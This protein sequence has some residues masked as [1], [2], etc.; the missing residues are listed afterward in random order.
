MQSNEER[1]ALITGRPV[2]SSEAGEGPGE[3][4]RPVRPALPCARAPQ[5]GPQADSRVG[6]VGDAGDPPLELLTRDVGAGGSDPA[7]LLSSLV[8]GGGGGQEQ[9]SP[10]V[11]FSLLLWPLLALVVRLTLDTEYSS[12][13]SHS[14]LLPFP[15]A[16]T[17]LLLTGHLSL[18]NLN[19]TSLLS[20][21]LMLCGLSQTKVTALTRALHLS[22]ILAN[23][24]ALY[25]FSFVLAHVFVELVIDSQLLQ[26]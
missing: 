4:E 23:S 3:T 1:L 22:S 7:A 14:A 10:P 2:E 11:Q 8:G 20:A 13:L 15:L 9:G 12:Y 17:G 5:Q 24:F 26:G 6:E 25:I 21:A 18:A 16:V 19:S